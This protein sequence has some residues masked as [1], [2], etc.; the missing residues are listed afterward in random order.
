MYKRQLLYFDSFLKKSESREELTDQA[1][2]YEQEYLLCGKGSDR[3][4]LAQTVEQLLMIRAAMNLLYLLNAADK[5]AQADGLAAAV[6]GGNA[7]AGQ[8]VGFL[9]LSLWALGEAVWDV[10]GL[11]DGGKTGFW[12]TDSTWH[13]SL[14]GLLAME[15]LEGRPDMEASGSGYED[16]IR[17]LLFLEDKLSL[18][19]I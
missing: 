15:F 12:K 13:L 11:L 18:I 10:R 17:I 9:I 2:D 8:I 16:Y 7:A 3:D 1:L 6:S 5:K 19:H 4:N 14:D